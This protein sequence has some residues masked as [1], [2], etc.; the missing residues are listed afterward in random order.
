MQSVGIG[1]VDDHVT[2]GAGDRAFAPPLD[3]EIVRARDLHHRKAA[4][5]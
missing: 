2:G 3:S 1:L 4:S 5:R